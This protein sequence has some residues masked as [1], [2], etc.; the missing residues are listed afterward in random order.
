MRLAMPFT[1]VVRKKIA[2]GVVGFFALLLLTAIIAAA[3]IYPT[4]PDL[5]ELSDYRPKMP[6][7]IYT[8]DGELMAEYGAERRDFLPLDKIPKRMQDALLAVEDTDFYQHGA[9]SYT[10]VMR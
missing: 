1:P 8:A 9:I 3:V 6:L 5:A 10:G 4:L 2:I 7:R